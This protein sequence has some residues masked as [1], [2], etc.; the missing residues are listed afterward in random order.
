MLTSTA[1]VAWRAISPV[2]RVSRWLPHISV[3]LMCFKVV[4]LAANKKD[5]GARSR[6]NDASASCRRTHG[7]G[8]SPTVAG[9]AAHDRRLLAQPE[10][11]DQLTILV[12][13]RSLQIIEQLAPAAHHAQ[14]AAPRMM[15]L[16]V[17]LEMLGEVRDARR[18]QRDLDLGRSGIALGAL[19]ILAPAGLSGWLVTAIVTLR[20]PLCR[21]ARILLSNP[22]FSSNTWPVCER[23]LR[24]LRLRSRRGTIRPGAVTSA[25]PQKLAG[26]GRR[27][28]PDPRARRSACA[29]RAGPALSRR[30][31]AASRSSRGSEATS[32]SAGSSSA[33]RS[34]GAICSSC[35][36]VTAPWRQR[37][38]ADR[39]PAAARTGRRRS[40][41]RA[42]CPRPAR[43]CR[44]PC[45]SSPR[46]VSSSPVDVRAGSGCVMT[47]AAR[48]ARQ[49]RV[50]RAPAC[51]AAARRA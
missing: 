44:C 45:C 1:P 20:V 41:A 13:V 50:R 37:E 16:D 40:P 6:V 42:R 38:A 11:V 22:G 39:R 7:A 28:A 51:R 48:R 18:Q 15:I 2:S 35:S 47:I 26:S 31:S 10:T 25:D 30:A 49:P 43:G 8:I 27:C 4:S 33:S 17:R 32:A 9:N 3:F 23:Q 14:Q 12:G 36:S 29:R 5:R 24:G 46:A 21:V 34:A 19:V